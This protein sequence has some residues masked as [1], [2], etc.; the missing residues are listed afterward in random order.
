MS[1]PRKQRKSS[2]GPTARNAYE[3]VDE[4]HG[5]G[6]LAG[7]F[8]AWTGLP[9][10]MWFAVFGAIAGAVAGAIGGGTSELAHTLHLGEGVGFGA[11]IAGTF[12][13]A[14]FGLLL[15]YRTLFTHPLALAG[16]LVSGALVGTA[17]LY[18]TVRFEDNILRLRGYRELSSRER[19][20]VDPVVDDVLARLGV[21]GK[22]PR[23]Y[24][25]EQVVPGAWTHAHSIVLSRGLLGAYDESENPPV[26]DM[27]MN[28][29][30]AVVAHEI[31]HWQ[32]ADGVGM[33]AVWC[34]CFPIL[35][36]YDVVHRVTASLD[37]Q[38]I[39]SKFRFQS[40]AW[41]VLWPAWVSVELVI[42]PAIGRASREAEYKADA[43]VA[44]LGDDYR[45]G[46]RTALGQLE[47][48]ERPRTGWEDAIQATHPAIEQRQERLEA[49]PL[50]SAVRPITVERDGL[51]TLV[52]LDPQVTALADLTVAAH[53]AGGETSAEDDALGACII[54]W[55]EVQS[56]DPTR[57][58]ALSVADHEVDKWL[59]VLRWQP[60]TMKSGA[61]PV[62]S[63]EKTLRPRV[64][65][66][67]TR[68]ARPAKRTTK[69]PARTKAPSAPR[70]PTAKKPT[71]RTTKESPSSE[72]VAARWQLPT[73]D[74]L[75]ETG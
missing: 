63:G 22:R 71:K 12:I 35:L 39:L 70:K 17:A 55:L 36:A 4:R 33:K 16:N 62:E 6:V 68:V 49:M 27:T 18:L 1:D 24:V 43:R 44:S 57:R 5:N 46:L 13:G 37:Q 56:T 3:Q 41:L 69:K 26:P 31:V 25:S 2:V 7:L 20:L 60:G 52:V 50:H 45:V 8:A 29:F 54:H 58:A 11:A 53:A 15:V 72:D 23:M 28:A 38:P 51:A 59:A 75:K 47:D 61:P 65:K 30:A 34:A 48:F 14:F 9:F 32:R 74:D 42:K 66:S 64:D 21:E 19:K 10:A 40:F 73:D 67:A